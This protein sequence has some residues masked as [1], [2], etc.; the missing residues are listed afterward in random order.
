MVQ[1]YVNTI[2]KIVHVFND[3]KIKLYCSVL[4][5]CQP[6]WKT[7]LLIIAFQSAQL[8]T[9]NQTS[10]SRKC[11][12]PFG[13]KETPEEHFTMIHLAISQAGSICLKFLNDHNGRKHW[14]I[15]GRKHGDIKGF[16]V[17]L[18]FGFFYNIDQIKLYFLLYFKKQSP[19]CIGIWWLCQH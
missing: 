3:I 18:H 15:L 16:F 2:V 11:I 13:E 10:L 9:W 17:W 12:L 19:A 8:R 7:S 6:N 5:D 1:K 14:G 4:N